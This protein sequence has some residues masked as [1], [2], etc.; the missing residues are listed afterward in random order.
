[1]DTQKLINQVVFPDRNL[2]IFQEAPYEW[3]EQEGFP[4]LYKAEVEKDIF[5][6]EVYKKGENFLYWG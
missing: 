4:L 1:M 3:L 6:G 2:L 5:W